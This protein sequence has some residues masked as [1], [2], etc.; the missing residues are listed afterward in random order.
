MVVGKQSILIIDDN[1][2]NIQLAANVL[3]SVNLYNVYFATSGENGIEQLRSREHSLI[4]L[5]INM[6]GLSGYETADL[7]KKDEK[8]KHIP[9]IFL[10]ANVNKQSI[11]D[12]FTH[13]GADYITKPFDE[14]EL[15]HR[16]KT[17]IELFVS[18]QRL[19]LEVDET[20]VLLEQYKVAVDSNSLVSKT[21]KNGIITYVNEPFCKVS[22]YSREELI[23]RSHNIIRNPNVS[24]DVYKELWDTITSKKTWN[25]VF[26]NR[27]KDG[28]SYFVDSTVM[29]ILDI[30][31]EILEYISI[32]NDI[33]QEVKLRAD[34]LSTQ[35]EIL[36][37]FGELGEW[38][39]QETGEHVNRV[40]L[41]SGVLARAYGCSQEDTDLLMM[42]SPMHDIGK[43]I[44]PDS[45]LLKPGRLTDEEFNLMKE[46]TTYG[47]KIFEHSKH[48][49]LQTAAII[50]YQHHEKWD[51]TGYPTGSSGEDIHL[52]GRIT[53]ICDVFD[54]LS[55]KRVYK[56]AWSMKETLEYIR[57][58][59][60]KA[61]EPKLVD[62]FLENLDEIL[63]IK[64]LHQN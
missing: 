58:E 3:M 9:I 17:H 1:T 2:K 42:A 14:L 10:S 53:S 18:K 35:K 47:W 31:G 19:Q 64:R 30:D 51:G 29:P 45:I 23:G 33:T 60:G 4:L 11:R 62:L 57:N 25:G 52:F 41:F 28:S 12:G 36:H 24:D 13:G 37:T 55:H 49:L 34:I 26:E 15:L 32:R 43:V 5:D 22:Q 8:L 6:P 48:T 21:D 38:R 44:I 56:K 50:A 39:S 46:H 54:A 16:V 61:F 20:K 27:A 7:I 59:R 40:S 63:E